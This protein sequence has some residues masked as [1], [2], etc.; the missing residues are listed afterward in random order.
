MINTKLIT[1][2]NEI[3]RIVLECIHL[4]KAENASLP[5]QYMHMP[6]SWWET[7]HSEQ[8]APFWQKRGK[9]F[10]GSQSRLEKFFILIARDGLGLCGA[11]PLVQFVLKMPAGQSNLNIITLAGDYVLHPFQDFIIAHAKRQE[12]I[13][14]M[15]EQIAGLIKKESLIFWAGYL[16]EE[17]PNLNVLRKGCASLQRQNVES[18]ETISSQ[19][20]G[21]WPWTIDEI[22]KTLKKI[23]S[24]CEQSGEEIEGLSDLTAN[25]AKCTPQSL[26]F[27]R[28]RIK[29]L[30][31][32]QD[33]LPCLQHREDL[34]GLAGK[35]ESFLKNSPILYPYIEL[36]DDCEE[37]L[38]SLSY[39]TRRYFRRYMKKFFE[40]GGSFETVPPDEITE[41]DIED[42]IRL[43]LLRWSAGSASICGEAADY[44]RMISK[45]MAQQGMFLLFF[46]RYKGK[47]IAVHSCFDI[48]TRREGYV[49]GLDPEYNELRAGRLLYIQTI[50]D[51]IDKGFS[52][53]E[54]GSVGFDYKMSFVKKTAVAHNFFLYTSGRDARLDQIFKGMEC[55]ECVSA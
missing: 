10:L 43:H 49:T 3:G 17:S 52:R 9:N 42:Y 39:S 14:V 37:Y 13:S 32:V 12:I 35:L 25:I 2:Q 23:S 31:E 27:P 6:I 28:T 7:F 33:F 4:A 24:I 36:P 53:Y 16:P 5:F 11:V 46:A 1:E 54:L 41:T 50:Y 40:A 45:A 47:R 29:L 15:L 19:R 26:L 18:F 8:N 51:A 38:A 55:M 44:H 21:V 30:Q 22:L 20:G 48:G 34:S